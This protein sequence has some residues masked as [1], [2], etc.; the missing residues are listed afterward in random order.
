MG[1]VEDRRPDLFWHAPCKT[2]DQTRTG[3]KQMKNEAKTQYSVI[4]KGGLREELWEWGDIEAAC[5]AGQFSP[6]SLI[7]IEKESGWKRAIDT[8]LAVLFDAPAAVERARKAQ[9]SAGDAEREAAYESAVQQIRNSPGDANLC[10]SAAEL[11]LGMGHEDAACDHFQNAL[12]ISPYHPRVAQEARRTLPRAKWKTLRFL[13]RPEEVWEDL[14]KVILYPFARGPL[15]MLLP[16]A[17]LTA[18]SLT[19]WSMI[20]CIMVLCPWVTE[21]IRASS[22]GEQRPP[23]WH[24]FFAN[25]LRTVA[26]PLA[27][28]VATGFVLCVPFLLIAGVLVLTGMS[29]QSN[30]F[31]VIK[32]SPALTVFLFTAALFYLPPVLMLTGASTGRFLDVLNPRYVGSIIRLMEKEY[33]K[34]VFFVGLLLCL[35]WGAGAFI[36]AVPFAARAL[37]ATAAVYILLAGGYVFGRLYARFAERLDHRSDGQ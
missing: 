18:A 14:L 10:L 31:L 30:I 3:Q 28:A 9:S 4:Q 37:H 17:V 29:H 27:A 34:A 6:G 26:R 32:K 1:P 33:V 36:D 25:P 7:F 11:A 19:V 2:L 20:P 24:G 21:V 15:Y 12:E 16:A 8:E 35:S 22:R 13:E 23:L 5:R